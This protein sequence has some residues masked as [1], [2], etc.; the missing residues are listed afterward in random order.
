[1]MTAW[2]PSGALRSR[3]TAI[4]LRLLGLGVLLFGLLYTHAVSPESTVGHVASGSGTS[5]AIAGHTAPGPEQPVAIATHGPA[6][7][8]VDHHGGDS[9]GQQHALDECGLGQPSQGPAL[10][11]P[12]LTSL[13]SA[14][15]TVVPPLVHIRP[16]AVRGFVVPIPHAA[17]SPVLRI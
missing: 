2:S 13:S 15:E 10:G 17:E 11:L 9:H 8:P 3:S 14:A 7:A 4:P 5:T 6:E 1:M 16:S 12:C